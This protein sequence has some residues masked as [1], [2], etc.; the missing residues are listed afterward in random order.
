MA[1]LG[2]HV[3][4]FRRKRLAGWGEAC[5]ASSKAFRKVAVLFPKRFC[6]K[7][8]KGSWVV[9]W[10]NILWREICISGDW[11][12]DPVCCPTCGYVEAVYNPVLWAGCIKQ[13][14]HGSFSCFPRMKTAFFI[15]GLAETASVTAEM[16]SQLYTFAYTVSPGSGLGMLSLQPPSWGFFSP[17]SFKF[18]EPMEMQCFHTGP[19]ICIPL[20][21]PNWERS[22]FKEICSGILSIPTCPLGH[23][24]C[25][26]Q[27]SQ[28]PAF[29]IIMLSVLGSK[30]MP[31]D[32][33]SWSP[34][35]ALVPSVI[36]QSCVWASKCKIQQSSR[37]K[38][39]LLHFT[40]KNNA[41]KLV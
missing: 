22:R 8:L 27:T 26:K 12:G 9:R 11:N 19:V 36:T 41:H 40:P 21:Y 13:L 37:C 30:P 20:V 14:P 18:L 25:Q 39:I 34:L 17:F 16:K 10:G 31:R 33:L 23:G 32:C 3:P 35:Y 24:G 7:S 1:L 6:S 5:K 38:L 28:H 2:L 15:F 4:S 29:A